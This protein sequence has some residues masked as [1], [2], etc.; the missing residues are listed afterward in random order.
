MGDAK[1]IEVRPIAGDDAARII[2]ALHYSGRIARRSRVNF[3][4]FLDGKCGGAL[5][6]GAPMDKRK[7][8]PLVQGTEWDQMLELNRMALADWLPRNGES[9][10]ISVCMRMLHRQ[11]PRLKWVVTFAD[12]TQCG[13]G[14]I[15]RAAGF[16]LTQIRR[17]V[18]MYRMPDGSV[19]AK[20]TIATANDSARHREI[21]RR[22]NR[23]V[24]ESD[25]RFL[26]RIGA[27]PLPGFQMRYI[28]L[29]DP[30]WRARLAVPVIPYS[31][32]SALGASMY[33][34]VAR[35]NPSIEGTGSLPE[36]RRCNSDPSAPPAEAAH[37]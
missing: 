37:G 25:V 7:M 15:Y 10:A 30:T 34:G 16:L 8:L 22:Y 24:G 11:Y 9:R 19:C 29:L 3:G 5:Q 33:R 14:T 27:V 17:N 12:G 23:G 26:R 2:R 6:F 13:D 35:S 4:V 31:K 28:A 32:I 1:R 20:L 18:T 36:Q 21:D